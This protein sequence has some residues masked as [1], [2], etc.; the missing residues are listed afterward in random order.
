[1]TKDER[2]NGGGESEN[3]SKG[4]RTTAKLKSIILKAT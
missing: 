1:L 2:G 3:N 4:S